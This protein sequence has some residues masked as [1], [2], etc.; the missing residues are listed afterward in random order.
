[1][2][3]NLNKNFF[4]QSKIAINYDISDIIQEQEK[5]K[6]EY[7]KKLIMINKEKPSL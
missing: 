1:M 2:G 6:K 5:Y 3:L 7:K 4:G